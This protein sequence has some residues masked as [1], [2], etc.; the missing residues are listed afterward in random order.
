MEYSLDYKKIA[1][2]IRKAKAKNVLIQ[3]PDG[4]KPDYKIIIIELSKLVKSNLFLWAGSCFGACDVPMQSSSAGID[5]IV[6]V[7]HKE[8]SK[9]DK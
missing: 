4:L 6:H 9:E 1:K 5:L 2:G 3:L 8:F 7:G